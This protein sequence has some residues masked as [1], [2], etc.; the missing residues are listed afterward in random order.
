[1]SME[2]LK[3]RISNS[4]LFTKLKSVKNF[5]LIIC[6][7]FIAILLLIYF[8][9]FETVN[10]GKT[11]QKTKLYNDYSQYTDNLESRLSSVLSKVKNAGNVDVMITLCSNPELVIAYN[12]EEKTITNSNGSQTVTVVK[13]PILINQSGSTNALILT[14]L[15]PEIKGVI[16]VAQGAKDVSVRL[17]LLNATKTVLGISLDKIQVFAGK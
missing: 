12:I 16:I 9:G 3:N 10:D 13:D 1:M 7:F 17:D 15:L 2:N 11:S 6:I 8:N 5:E 4:R 14:E